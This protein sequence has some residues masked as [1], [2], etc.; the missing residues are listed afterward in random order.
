MAGEGGCHTCIIFLCVLVPQ[1]AALAWPVFEP[2]LYTIN[3]YIGAALFLLSGILCHWSH[4][5]LGKHWYADGQVGAGHTVVDGGCYSFVRH[6]M[7]TAFCMQALGSALLWSYYIVMGCF[8]L[9]F[10]LNVVLFYLRSRREEK[11]LE[12][13]LGA[14][15]TEYMKKVRG[16]IIP[17][18]L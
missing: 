17:Y 10:V 3:A 16:R 6:P 5:Y 8:L 9:I 14:P 1:W 11:M 18:I 7:Y 2:N 15:Y 13:E 4:W 12:R